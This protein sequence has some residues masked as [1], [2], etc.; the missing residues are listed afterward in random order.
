MPSLQFDFLAKTRKGTREDKALDLSLFSRFVQGLHTPGGLDSN[1]S[2][3]PA[4]TLDLKPLAL[5][6][7]LFEASGH[8]P[9]MHCGPWH[10]HGSLQEK[11]SKCDFLAPV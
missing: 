3:R 2:F 6:G 11:E 4:P 1:L 8:K 7:H 10:A 5:W 9:Y